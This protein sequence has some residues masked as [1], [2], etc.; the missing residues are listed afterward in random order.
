MLQYGPA[1][2]LRCG[3]YEESAPDKLPTALQAPSLPQVSALCLRVT[4]LLSLSPAPSDP[5]LPRGSVS[6][7]T[8]H[9]RGVPWPQ[10]WLC[11]MLTLRL[12]ATDP[13]SQPSSPDPALCPF[14]PCPL[15]PRGSVSG[16]TCHLRASPGGVL[17]GCMLEPLGS[18]SAAKAFSCH[19]RGVPW[20]V[21]RLCGARVRCSDEGRT[22]SRFMK[23]LSER[24]EARRGPTSAGRR[25]DPVCGDPVCGEPVRGDPVLFVRE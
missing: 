24:H 5:A 4:E 21:P 2:I 19:R 14:A 8:C 7:A 22:T 12:R 11:D 1:T 15:V 10:P 20:P 23:K 9:R 13:S 6:A 18:V 17:C 3:T 25:G 16:G